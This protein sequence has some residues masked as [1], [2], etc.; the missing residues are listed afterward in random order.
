MLIIQ[1]KFRKTKNLIFIYLEALF[2]PQK[3]VVH[4][5]CIK[6]TTL[7]ENPYII[8]KYKQLLI[9]LPNRMSLNKSIYADIFLYSSLIM[10]LKENLVWK[11]LNQLKLKV[12][13][14]ERLL[15]YQK[16]IKLNFCVKRQF[17]KNKLLMWSNLKKMKT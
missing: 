4:K 13:K 17:Y 14:V 3:L 16:N 12:K 7:I 1:T 5:M 6:F 11:K 10:K 2:H 8:I 9:N 15:T